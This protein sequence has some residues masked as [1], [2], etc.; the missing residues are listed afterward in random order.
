M[1]L[2]YFSKAP[3]A[4]PSHTG[5]SSRAPAHN[6]RPSVSDPELDEVTTESQSLAALTMSSDTEEPEY[7]GAMSG[8]S[9]SLPDVS[10]SEED[11]SVPLYCSILMLE[12][13]A[14]N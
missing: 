8:C 14:F 9:S 3:Q 4:D 6:P 1:S 5:L 13:Y 11:P 7:Q 12:M 2:K 10:D